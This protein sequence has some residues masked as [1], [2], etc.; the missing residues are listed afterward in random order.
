MRLSQSHALNSP[1]YQDLVEKYGAPLQL[2]APTAAARTRRQG[3]VCHVLA[4]PLHG[5]SFAKIDDGLYV[6]TPEFV[7][8]Q[9]AGVMSL[10]RLILLGF[11]L[12]GTYTASGKNGFASNSFALTAPAKIKRFVEGAPRCKGR[13]QALRATKYVLSGSASPKE[14]Q[15]AM[16]LCLPYRLGGYGLQQP[17]MNR[18]IELDP[19]TQFLLKKRFVVCDLYWSAAKLDLEYDS[20]EFHSTKE[21]LVADARRR[22]A[23][24]SRGIAS[25]NVTSSQIAQPDEIEALAKTVARMLGKQ[26]R[27]PHDFSSHIHTLRAEIGV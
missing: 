2:V 4:Q 20:T 16:L 25:I 11:E 26:I 18:R 10:E 1:D 5:R 19:V 14:S 8:L 23:L 22:A 7:F 21:K 6:S 13:A 12:C 24:E 9:M 27:P 15:L 17:E 3:S